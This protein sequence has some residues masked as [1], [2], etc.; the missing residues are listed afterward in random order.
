VQRRVPARQTG[1]DSAA[2]PPMSQAERRTHIRPGRRRRR[3]RRS[4]IGRFGDCRSKPPSAAR[5]THRCTRRGRVDG[6]G[7]TRVPQYPTCTRNTKQQARPEGRLWF[8]LWVTV[9]D[10]STHEDSE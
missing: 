6:V 10:R 3:W 5:W 4:A 8:R 7:P 1:G 2:N 9:N